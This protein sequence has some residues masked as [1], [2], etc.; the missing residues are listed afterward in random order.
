MHS[1][2][3][4]GLGRLPWVLVA[5]ATVMTL[6]LFALT[7]GSEHAADQT[8]TLRKGGPLP[9][10][11][12][13]PDRPAPAETLTPAGE[14]I[15]IPIYPPWSEADAEALFAI[16]AIEMFDPYCGKLYKPS[17]HFTVPFFEHPDQQ[18]EFVINSRSMREDT[19]PLPGK[20]LLRILVA[21]DS[22][23]EGVCKNSESF[24]NQT[25]GGLRRRALTQS[26]KRGE[27]FD[28]NSI[29][30]LNAGKGGYSFFNYL[31]V[32][33]RNLDL[34]PDI[35]VVAIYGG[36]DFEESLSAWHYYFNEGKRPAGVEFYA[37]EVKAAEQVYRGAL[38]QSMLSVKYFDVHPEQKAIAIE[39]GAQVFEQTKALCLERGIRLLVLYLPP[40]QDIE[41]GNPQLRLEGLLK[42]LNLKPEALENTQEMAGALL[43]RLAALGIET[44]DM[45]PA[46]RQA[47]ES[48]YWKAD[49]HINLAGHRVIAGAL[50]DAL[51][52]PR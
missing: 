11:S 6:A 16:S 27:E 26:R 19:D 28:L 33:E 32:L 4:Q 52:E 30:V 18:I 37:E 35:F 21:G 24:A 48:L 15:K 34:A 42:A 10:W 8:V 9:A 38:S 45:R 14:P 43:K 17:Q 36:N 25:E 40:R 2:A 23:T 47:A 50:I 44:I 31:G 46:F 49:W 1:P 3:D 7:R 13:G 41:P 29:E 5:I 51:S 22:H 20:P 12:P 39:A